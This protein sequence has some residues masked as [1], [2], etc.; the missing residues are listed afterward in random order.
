MREKFR[1]MKLSFLLLMKVVWTLQRLVTSMHDQL[2]QSESNN[3]EVFS[4][5]P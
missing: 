3:C 2:T 1:K 5:I 4:S